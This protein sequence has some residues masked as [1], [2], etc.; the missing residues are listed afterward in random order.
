MIFTIRN[1][2]FDQ[3]GSN[4][5]CNHRGGGGIMEAANKGASDGGGKSVGM[6]IQLPL[7]KAKSLC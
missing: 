5:L 2:N 3:S 1:R 6:N 7:N 4:D